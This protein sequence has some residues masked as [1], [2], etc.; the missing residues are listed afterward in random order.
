[1]GALAI[2]SFVI[3]NMP[4]WI[5]SGYKLYGLYEKTREVIDANKGPDAPEWNELDERA[6]ALE[7]R[8]NDTSKDA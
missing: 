1:M 5:E 3:G 8:I 6:K 4:S 7:A 2:A